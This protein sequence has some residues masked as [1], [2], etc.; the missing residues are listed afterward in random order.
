MVDTYIN[1][2]PLAISNKNQLEN[3][4]HYPSVICGLASQGKV[5]LDQLYCC[6]K[7]NGCN[8]DSSNCFGDS[9]RISRCYNISA[10]EACQRTD[11]NASRVCDYEGG[12]FCLST[13][14]TSSDRVELNEALK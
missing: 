10:L 1:I 11:F 3:I 8:A 14:T 2:M 6:S 12:L 13:K 5:S 4:N 9:D 7:E